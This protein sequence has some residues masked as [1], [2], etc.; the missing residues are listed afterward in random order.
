MI[1]LRK[2]KKDF[3]SLENF[4]KNLSHPLTLPQIEYLRKHYPIG[5]IIDQTTAYNGSG[6][7]TAKIQSDTFIS[8]K[9]G[10]YINIHCGGIGIWN[11]NFKILAK[12]VK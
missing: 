4:E 1:R 5:T 10:A 8:S 2:I 7:R 12:I 3:I 11:S 9:R 6:N